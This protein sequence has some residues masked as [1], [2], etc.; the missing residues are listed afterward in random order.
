[1]DRDTAFEYFIKSRL[2]TKTFKKKNWLKKSQNTP[3]TRKWNKPIRQLINS[4]SVNTNKRYFKSYPKYKA[5][6][7]P[8]KKLCDITSL[9]TKYVNTKMFSIYYYNSEVY[10]FIDAYLSE[11]DAQM[12]VKLRNGE[13]EK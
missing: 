6:Y 10:N 12:Y 4:N 13:W 5:Y 9:P 2:D 11:Y 8:T 3:I 1:M 7:Y